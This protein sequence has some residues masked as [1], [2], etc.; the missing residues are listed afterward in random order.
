MRVANWI[1]LIAIVSPGMGPALASDDGCEFRAER[2]ASI[3]ATGVTKIVLRTGA[4]DLDVN[5]RANS[6]RIEAHGTASAAKQELLD[7]VQLTVR[8]EG[9]VVYL[10]TQMPQDLGGWSW[11]KNEYASIDLIVAVPDLVAVGAVDSSGDAT[12]KDL[13]SLILQDSSGDL[14]VARV[15]GTVDVGDGSGALE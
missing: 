1:A 9:N 2:K 7:K 3:D 15:A 5:G 6:T 13:D 4:G 12:F 11:G 8:R 10:E 14:D